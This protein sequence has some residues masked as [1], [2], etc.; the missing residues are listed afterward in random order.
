MRAA[1]NG[2]AEALRALLSSA[3]QVD[4]AANDGFT[5]LMMAAKNGHLEC[6][7]DLAEGG[8]PPEPSQINPRTPGNPESLQIS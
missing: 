6:V 7:Q 8:N 5:A 3:A 1:H 2:H 4:V